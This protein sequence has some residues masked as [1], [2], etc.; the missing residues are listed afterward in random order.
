MIRKSDALTKLTADDTALVKAL[1]QK[2][3]A[4]IA[5][6]RGDPLYISM[7]YPNPRV[8]RALIEKAKAAGWSLRF[9]D[10]QRD[11]SSAILS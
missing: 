6:Y 7:D 2:I 11:G 8:E 10:D 9:V 4:A 1:E 5:K 3:D